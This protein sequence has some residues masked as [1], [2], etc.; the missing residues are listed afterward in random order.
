MSFE[1]MIII[2]ESAT[3]GLNYE[4]RCIFMSFPFMVGRRYWLLVFCTRLHCKVSRI[5]IVRSFAWLIPM[6]VKTYLHRVLPLTMH[7]PCR[8]M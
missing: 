5:Y 1:R 2:N 7:L 4:H 6:S 3:L 8:E